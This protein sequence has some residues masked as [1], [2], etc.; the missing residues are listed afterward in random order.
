MKIIAVGVETRELEFDERFVLASSTLAMDPCDL[1]RVKTDEGLTGLG[2]ACP[3]YEFTGDTLWTVQDVIGECLGPVVTGNA[4]FQ[5]EAI[6]RCWERE[7]YTVAN[8][9]AEAGLEIAL[10]DPQG[11]ALGRQHRGRPRRGHRLGP[12]RARC[13]G[14]EDARHARRGHQRVQDQSRWPP[15]ARRAARRRR[16]PGRR[17]ARITVDA[18]QGWGDAKTAVRAIKLLEPHDIEFVEQPLRMDDLEAARWVRDRV[19]VPIALDESI[20][21]RRLRHPQ[22]A[23]AERHRRSR[24][25]HHHDEQHGESSLGLGAHF[26][27]NVALANTVHCDADLPWLP[28]GFTHDIMAGWGWSS[29]TASP[30]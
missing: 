19:D 17:C 25:Q 22:C 24:Q 21:G 29:A 14:R 26:H 18:N 1:V 11:E 30:P 2:E 28:G 5:L 13:A 16:A 3:A 4:P 27:V 15:G 8:Q 12:G 23:Q 9:A 20:R 10:W 7:L 6:T